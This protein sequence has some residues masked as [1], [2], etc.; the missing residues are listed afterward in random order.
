MNPKLS[1]LIPTVVERSKQFIK[2][3]EELHFWRK[4]LKLEDQIEILNLCDN[5]EMTIGEKR[6]RLYAM[7][8]GKYSWQVDDD[9]TIVCYHLPQI[10]KAME[11]EPDCITFLEL[12]I[13][14]GVYSVSKFSSLYTDWGENIDGFD[15]VRTPFFKTPI[16]SD[17]CKQVPVPHSRFG[18]D[19]EWARAVKPLIQSEFHIPEFVYRYEHVSSPH[20]ERYGIKENT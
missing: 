10:I 18:E 19:H 2:L 11:E 7:A 12:C 9:D 20:N 13:I 5:K 6:E 14:D 8:N 15:H 17:I 16:K 1:I 4:L 3:W